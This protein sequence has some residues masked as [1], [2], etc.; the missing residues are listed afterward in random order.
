MEIL[1]YTDKKWYAPVKTPHVQLRQLLLHVRKNDRLHD[2]TSAVAAK[3]RTLLPKMDIRVFFATALTSLKSAVPYLWVVP[4]AVI[5]ALVPLTVTKLISYTES[6]A[7][8][9]AFDSAGDTTGELLENA[10]S[11]F[12]LN[13]N[14]S[15]S[16]DGTVLNE[17]GSSVNGIT[18]SFKQPVTF[19]NYRV[20][21]GDT[22]DGISRRFGLTNISTLIAVNNISNVRSL[23]SGQKLRIP[24]TDGIV[25]TVTRGETLN[26][27][28][29][30]FSVSVE[31]LLDVNDLTSEILSVGDELFI[32]GV[33]LDSNSLRKALG[34]LFAYPIR[35]KWRLT[36]R[37]GPRINPVTLVPSRHTGIDMACPTGTPI[38]AAMSGRIA[39]T[40]ISN[41]YGYYVIITHYDGYQTLYG[42]MSKILATKGQYVDQGALIGLVGS[43]GQSTGPHLHFTV[44]KNGKLI[45]PLTVLK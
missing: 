15:Y 2:A 20:R 5:V 24:S 34:E 13:I 44:Y 32:P 40:G 14:G 9:V 42:H 37:F 28:S 18:Y 10:L 6:F 25:H 29:V 19:Q 4:A 27:L 41:V 1:S 22:I 36:D 21:A 38:K 39:Y 26:G 3:P 33:K 17:D 12:A 11:V 45:D 16:L 43:T 8:E 35:A 7:H 31:D 30:K 23:R